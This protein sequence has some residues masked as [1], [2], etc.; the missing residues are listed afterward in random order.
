MRTKGL[1]GH[2]LDVVERQVGAIVHLVDDLMDLSRIGRGQIELHK[3]HIEI[4]DVVARAIETVDPLLKEHG[5]RLIPLVPESGLRVNVDPSRMAQVIANLLT[6]AAK[7]S[8]RGSEITVR[9]V[10]DDRRLRLSVEDQG[11][12]I[13]PEMMPHV[14]EAFAQA[15][16]AVGRSLGGLGLGLAIVRNLVEL[17][18]GAVTV[19]SDG[20]GTGSTFCVE[21]ALDDGVVRARTY[22]QRVEDDDEEVTTG[23]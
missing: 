15:R 10:R 20:L 1:S 6:N 11:I 5:H 18:D 9:A 14:F 17:H 12:G 22:K 16:G 7:Y 21:L 19:H 4:A 8:E 3:K 13:A 23:R 2:E